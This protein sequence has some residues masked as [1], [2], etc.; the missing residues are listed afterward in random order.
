MRRDRIVSKSKP[1]A[2]FRPLEA[3]PLKVTGHFQMTAK[4]QVIYE[5]TTILHLSPEGMHTN[6]SPARMVAEHLSGFLRPE[7]LHFEEIKFDLSTPALVCSHG[8]R[9]REII[10]GVDL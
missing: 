1:D 10:R 9:L 5:E 6:G 2:T 3:S 4:S 7:H 8:L